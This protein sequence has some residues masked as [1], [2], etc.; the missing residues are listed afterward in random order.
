VE[1]TG[2]DV[3]T[4]LQLKSAWF[5]VQGQAKP[6]IVAP[7]AG[8]G[9]GSGGGSPLGGAVTDVS[10]GLLPSVL[11]AITKAIGGATSPSTTPPSTSAPS[12]SA[13][14]TS[15][16]STGG[17]S[18]VVGSITQGIGGIASNATTQFLTAA[19]AAIDAKI[20]ELG[21]PTGVLGQVL[22]PVIQLVGGA[23]QKFA[24][25]T[26]YFSPDTGAHALAGS[27]L[28]DF[29]AKGAEGALGFPTRD[30]L[31]G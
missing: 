7:P 9:A 25:G 3:R 30:A 5:T 2:D 14:A 18:G 8:V 26:V 24:S 22:S 20:A 27:A 10:G 23:M 31:G 11:D 29:V 17:A 28:T 12:T 4:K 13:P 1:T 19:I 21:G 15:A 16:P 6:R